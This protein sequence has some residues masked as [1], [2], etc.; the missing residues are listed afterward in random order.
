[1]LHSGGLNSTAEGVLACEAVSTLPTGSDACHYVRAN[2]EED[3][4]V[5]YIGI[6]YCYVRSA[7]L[8][9]VLSFQAACVLWLLLVFRVLGSTAE[10]FFSPI[11]TQLAQELTL[12]PRLAGVTLLALGNGA[13]DLSS[14]IAAVSAGHYELAI[15]ALLGGGMFV[16]CVVAGAVVLASGGAKARGALL[17]DVAAYLVAVGA[18]MG[19]LASGSAT[20]GRAAALLALYAAF[21]AVVLGADMWRI[22]RERLREQQALGSGKVSKT[23]PEELP[24]LDERDLESPSPLPAAPLPPVADLPML[25]ELDARRVVSQPLPDACIE[26]THSSAEEEGAGASN[27]SAAPAPSSAI[28]T[29]ASPSRQR[30]ETWLQEGGAPLSPRAYQPARANGAS[31]GCPSGSTHSMAERC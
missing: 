1:M 23:A 5:P 27:R 6:F 14:S 28:P 2:C 16:G 13:P 3:S 10:D 7:G 19:V 29:Q 15:N 25:A 26:L 31:Y 30:V 24:L 20:A 21:V 17:R 12:P 8:P 18:A 11:L 9:A 4:V 22:V